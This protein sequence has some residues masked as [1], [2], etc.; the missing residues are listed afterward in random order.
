MDKRKANLLLDRISNLN[1]QLMRL[2]KLSEDIN[3]NENEMS[4]I[5]QDMTAYNFDILYEVWDLKVET[6]YPD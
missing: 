2:E 6:N 5:L 1:Y 4:Q 3:K